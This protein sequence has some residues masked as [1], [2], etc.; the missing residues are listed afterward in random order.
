MHEAYMRQ[1]ITA[2]HKS[3]KDG[4]MPIG[5]V[6]INRH[7]GDVFSMGESIVGLTKDPTSHA[8]ITCIRAACSA[9]Q[10]D[11]LSDFV[12]YCTLEPCQMCLSCAAWASVEQIYF[13][14]YRK[15][16]D[17]NLFETL[18]STGDE[19]AAANMRLKTH[20]KMHVQG[21]IL[22]AACIALLKQGV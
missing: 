1:A 13:G 11:D 3:Q 14:A 22:E 2:A 8:E 15:N 9:R 18:H 4:G 12:L 20:H 16:V 21:G 19:V 6:L 7:S 17:P 5:A 10:S